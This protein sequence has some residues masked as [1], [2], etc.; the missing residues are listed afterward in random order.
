[1]WKVIQG[2]PVRAVGLS[3]VWKPGGN[4]VVAQRVISSEGNKYFQDK[5]PFGRLAIWDGQVRV[6]LQM[7]ISLGCVHNFVIHVF[8]P[9]NNKKSK[10]VAY[11][12]DLTTF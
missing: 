10:A 8:S 11:K 5:L 1:M 6:E 2:Q 3:I 4:T 12:S 7:S 9:P